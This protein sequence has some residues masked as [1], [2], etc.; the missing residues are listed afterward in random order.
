MARLLVLCAVLGVAAIGVTAAVTAGKH[1]VNGI[2]HRI[3]AQVP[4][5]LTPPSTSGK[6]KAASSG[7]LLR[8]KPLR[9]ALAKLPA[10][11]I[12]TLR[13]A[14]DKVSAIV[15]HGKTRHV[16]QLG[17]D[18]SKIDVKTPS[19]SLD[20]PG[21]KVVPAAPFRIARKAAKLS[22]HSVSDVDY[23]VLSSGGWELFFKDGAHFHASASGA[24]VT[25]IG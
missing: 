6:P 21:A 25:K 7:S 11:R 10:G 15:D 20:L 24:K 19:V 14:P 3:D 16:V 22:H 1:A 4:S 9:A 12:F 8:E 13:V 17:A 2:R 23:L 18:G 5:T